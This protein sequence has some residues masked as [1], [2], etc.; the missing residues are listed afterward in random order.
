MRAG[1]WEVTLPSP[2][3]SV[4]MRG[5]DAIDDGGAD[6]GGICAQYSA[7]NEKFLSYL[8]I[9]VLICSLI[10]FP[11]VQAKERCNMT[12]PCCSVFFEML[13]FHHEDQVCRN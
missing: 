4:Q 9:L 6:Y 3:C 8:N 10:K 12:Q 7:H 13:R 5:Y 1:C 2:I 11:T